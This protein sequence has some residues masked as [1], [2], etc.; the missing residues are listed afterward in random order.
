MFSLDSASCLLLTLVIA[1]HALVANNAPEVRRF[2]LDARKDVSMRWVF[3]EGLYAGSAL[4]GDQSST[5]AHEE[6]ARQDQSHQCLP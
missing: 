1:P 4:G 5:R 6:E 3:A 2:L